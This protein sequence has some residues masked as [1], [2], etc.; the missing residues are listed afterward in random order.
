MSD[1]RVLVALSDAEIADFFPGELWAELQCVAG[2][3]GRLPLPLSDPGDWPRLLREHSAEVLVS[4]WQ[5][6]SLNSTVIPADLAGLR[7]VCHVAGTVRRLVPRE[8]IE[9][10]L[11]VTNWGSSISATVAECTLMLI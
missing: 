11:V 3:A 8:L 2:N 9:G 10:G 1:K 5:T 6:P 7:Y 4:C